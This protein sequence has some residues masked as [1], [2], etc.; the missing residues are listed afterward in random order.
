MRTLIV[1]FIAFAFIATSC[2]KYPE[3]PDFSLRSKT[4]RL[5]NTWKI[6]KWYDDGVDATSNFQILC[7]DYLR[8]IEKSGSYTATYKALSVFPVTETGTWAFNG[9]KSKV[10]FI[11]TSPLPQATEEWTILMLKEDELWAQYSDTG[12]SVIKAQL[13]PN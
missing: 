13:I 6:D 4:E 1:V 9:D 5:S 3:G 12:S 2:K 10:T 11:K 7:K 8:T